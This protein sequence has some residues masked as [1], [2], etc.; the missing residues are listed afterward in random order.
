MTT[1]M[2]AMATSAGIA[3]VILL[4]LGLIMLIAYA[5]VR[6]VYVLVLS[7]ALM[8]AGGIMLGVATDVISIAWNG[9]DTPTT[10]TTTTE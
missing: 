8:V 5:Q 3:S 7:L 10:G 9:W 2:D 1:I 4:V 6:N